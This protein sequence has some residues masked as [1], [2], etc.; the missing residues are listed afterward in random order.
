M[1]DPAVQVPVPRGAG[2]QPRVGKAGQGMRDRRPFR[3]GEPPEQR[4]RQRQRELD[5]ARLDTSPAGGQVPEQQ[6]EA[7]LEARLRGD[8]PLDVE[9][10][11]APR[12]PGAAG[13]G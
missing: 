2:D 5:A 11:S 1:L 7:N 6:R 4:V 8:G 10:A 3:G 12:G 9:I 13:H